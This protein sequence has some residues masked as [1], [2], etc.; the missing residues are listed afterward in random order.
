VTVDLDMKNKKHAGKGSFRF[1]K[2]RNVVISD[3]LKT[4]EKLL[5]IAMRGFFHFLKTRKIA[6]CFRNLGKVF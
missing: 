5:R 3:K 2:V 4:L 1:K 6:A